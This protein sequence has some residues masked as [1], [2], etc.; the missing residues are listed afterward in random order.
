MKRRLV[1]VSASS[2]IIG[3]DSGEVQ[4]IERYDGVFIRIVRKSIREGYLNQRDVLIVS[5]VL[6]LVRGLDPIPLHKP[7]EGTWHEPRLDRHKLENMN[8][9]ALRLLKKLIDSGEYS[10]VY[11]NVGTRLYPIIAGI[12][13]LNC[14][15]VYAKGRG[16]GPKAA[17]MK[18]WLYSKN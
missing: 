15:L 12:D 11:V 17:D 6:G 14:R 2:R 18:A 10:E 13:R 4:A 5:P 1:V 16:L 9:S 7:I 8:E 3:P